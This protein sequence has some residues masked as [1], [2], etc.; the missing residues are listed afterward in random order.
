MRSPVHKKIGYVVNAFPMVSE[1]FL[2]NELRAMESSGVPIAVFALSRRR[3]Q[4]RHGHVDEI[5]A[6]TYRPAGWSP[7]G[8]LRALRAHALVMWRQPRGYMALLRKDV[9]SALTQVWRSPDRAAIKRVR[10]KTGLF[11]TTVRVADAARR[12]GVAHLHAHYAKEPLDVAYRIRGLGGIPFSF[13]AHAKDLYTTPRSRLRR[14]IGKAKFAVACHRH[15]YSRLRAIAE[16][17]DRKKVI[18]IRHGVDKA[19]FQPGPERRDERLIVAA[20]RLT[21][22]KGFDLLIRACGELARRGTEFHCVIVGEGRLEAELRRQAA[23]RGVASRVEILRFLPQEELVSMYRRAALVALPARVLEGGNRDGIPNVLVESMAVATPVVSSRVGSIPELV[24]DGHNGLLIEPEDC[25]ALVAAL[26]RL[27]ADP[28]LSR[29]LGDNAARSKLAADFRR[30]NRPL[31]ERFRAAVGVDVDDAVARAGEAA[32][33]NDGTAATAA[34]LLGI[35]P[36]RSPSA[37]AGIV[38]GITPGLYANAWRADFDRMVRKR[39]WDEVYKGR[40]LERMGFDELASGGDDTSHPLRVL[41]LGCGRGGLTVALRARGVR[42]VGLDVRPRNCRTT[43]FRGQRYG[44]RVPACAAAGEALPFAD[45]SFDVVFM[46]ELLEHVQSPEQLLREANRICRPGGRCVVTVVNRWAHLDP[47]YHLWGI[48]FMPRKLAN[49]YIELRR[50]SK[51]S[52][53]DNQTLDDM[54]YFRWK[55]FQ[56][57][58][59]ALGFD[60]VDIEQPTGA[61]TGALH[62]LARRASLG[63]NTATVVLT[64]R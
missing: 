30:T 48:N 47:H 60:V 6:P 53:R 58:A 43:R 39:L 2:A 45:D 33:R 9:G 23:V 15:G 64:P 41:D 56:R 52:W 22:K 18:Q 57:V 20:G 44:D 16:P 40:R 63:F 46:L 25:G 61:L 29:R 10:K 54:H 1:T 31:V 62:R 55:R 19:I 27:L 4:V 42:T 17:Q 3:D 5:V 8:W 32:W 35:V 37:E 24:T 28:V 12:E 51:V 34:R 13:A 14:R 59:G 21:P 38:R 36:S 11:L 49:G 50:R 26:G 7:L